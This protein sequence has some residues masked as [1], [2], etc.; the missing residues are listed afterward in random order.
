MKLLYTAT[1]FN[2]LQH[3]AAHCSTLQHIAAHCSTLQH[4]A[5]HNSAQQHTAT[6]TCIYT[7]ATTNFNAPSAAHCNTPHHSTT[8]HDTTHCSILQHT[9]TTRQH[10]PA[11]TL[12]LQPTQTPHRQHNAMQYT[13][14][15]RAATALQQHC[16][17][18]ATQTRVIRFRDHKLQGLIGKSEFNIIV[19]FQRLCKKSRV[20]QFCC[21][22]VAMLLQCV[23][24]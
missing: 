10:K 21:S 4:T 22:V 16:N 13:S 11:S 14:T 7:F 18:T 20:L 12:P 15:Q 5:T 24:E 3:T 8:Q 9:A 17:S 1:H 2:T 6:Q 23:A 19:A